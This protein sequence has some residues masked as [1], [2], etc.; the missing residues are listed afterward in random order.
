MM[1]FQ[2]EAKGFIDPE[3]M[4]AAYLVRYYGNQKIEYPI[5]PFQ[6]LKA[7]GALFSLRKFKKLEGVYIPAA[8]EDD[9]PMV[10]INI[11]RPITRQRFTAAHELCHH[12][13]DADREVSCPI[14]GKKNSIED[15]A[16]KFAAALLMPINELRH[17]VNKRQK[18]GRRYISFDDVLVIADFFGVSF[19]ACL[20]R[21]AY[22]VHAIDG[23][24]EPQALKSRAAK[25]KP[26]KVRKSRH[27]TYSQLYAGLLDA[28]H[29][30]LTFVP[31]DFAR[32]IFQTEYIYNDSRMEGL[33]VT[34][35]QA[36]EIVADLRM[37]TQNSEYCSEENEAY[38][39][40]AGHYDMYM[41]IFAE[42][43]KES[44]TV[45]DMFALNK[46]LFSHYPHPEFGGASRQ[47]NTLVLG[48]KFETVDYHDIFTELAKVDAEVKDYFNRKSA[49]PMSEYIK[50]V[51]RVHHRITVIHPF[52]EGN[53]R[54]SRA[55]MN[56]Q[57]VRARIL[58]IYIKVEDKS[59]YIDALARV[60][61]QKDYDE[62]Y[63]IIFKLILRSF[64][65]LNKIS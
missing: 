31:T 34:L 21:I 6:M 7:E 33:D 3:E 62:L 30:Q 25:Y 42:P 51:A 27:M 44:L 50:H 15:F 10:G 36:S 8:G 52:P 1:Q 59:D 48:A 55:F 13:R 45:F 58:P 43:V 60:D 4:A 53:G 22:K 17:Q 29:E 40:I 2:T 38:L 9:I 49:I 65:D 23:D 14:N 61:K 63:E 35:E 46:K 18:N 5:N 56:V 16:E 20:F 41:D 37:N 32:Y 12:F 54:T 28:Y 11:N 24:T 57:L 39:S 47:N 64:V 26:E 19:E